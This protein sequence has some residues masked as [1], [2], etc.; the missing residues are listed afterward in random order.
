MAM[1]K[2]VLSRNPDFRNQ[3]TNSILLKKWRVLLTRFLR[4]TTGRL[5]FHVIKTSS[6]TEHSEF[7]AQVDKFDDESISFRWS[8]TTCQQKSIDPR[9]I[10]GIRQVTFDEYMTNSQIRSY[11]NA[12]S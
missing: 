12:P 7:I 10:I 8:T 1:N 4:I 5:K 2:I 3:Y 11:I 6:G 9:Y